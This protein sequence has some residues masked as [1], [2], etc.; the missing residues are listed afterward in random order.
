MATSSFQKNF[1]VTRKQQ[2]RVVSVM[3]SDKLGS[4]MSKK[5]ESKFSSAKNFQ[6]QLNNVL[7]PKKVLN[8]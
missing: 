3:T 8:D 7:S 1:T 4:N 5:F 6:G 2:D